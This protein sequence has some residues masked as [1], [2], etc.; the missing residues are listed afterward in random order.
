MKF[1]IFS[2]VTLL[3]VSFTSLAGIKDYDETYKCGTVRNP[4][5]RLARITSVDPCS[6]DEL[7]YTLS[8]GLKDE[9]KDLDV[10]GPSD[11]FTFEDGYSIFS[12][13]VDVGGNCYTF[14]TLADES[15]GSVSEIVLPEGV[16]LVESIDVTKILKA[17]R[18]FF[19][20]PIVFH[21]ANIGEVKSSSTFAGKIGKGF[22]WLG[23]TTF[24]IQ[25]GALIKDAC[26]G[27]KIDDKVY[28]VAKN[29]LN[30]AV[31]KL[32]TS[33]LQLAF[34]GVFAIDYSL[35]NF[36]KAAQ[37]QH[38]DNIRQIYFNYTYKQRTMPDWFRALDK[39]VQEASKGD[40][41]MSLTNIV[42]QEIQTVAQRFWKDNDSA[43]ETLK[44][45]KW[46]SK[47]EQK[48]LTEEMVQSLKYTMAQSGVFDRVY[49]SI[50]ERLRDEAVKKE[51]YVAKQ[52]NRKMV[53]AVKP[54]SA[55]G[56]DAQRNA[57]NKNKYAGYTVFLCPVNGS[58]TPWSFKLDD[59]GTGQIDFTVLG[60]F[61]CGCPRTCEIYA[62]GKVRGRDKPENSFK[63]PLADPRTT[64]FLPDDQP[65]EIDG[66]YELTSQTVVHKG[67]DTWVGK[68]PTSWRVKASGETMTVSLVGSGK[69][70]QVFTGKFDP[71]K[72]VFLF[73]QTYSS[74]GHN[75]E[76]RIELTF[77]G[78]G[79]DV[80][81]SGYYKVIRGACCEAGRARY[82]DQSLTEKYEGRKVKDGEK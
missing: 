52:L 21:K 27:E 47:E 33:G 72:G 9:L 49:S 77:T 5:T 17:N 67:G 60:F 59:A 20:E 7:R 37:E 78:S 22:T 57:D 56:G 63:F 50:M 76:R 80:K 65:A 14:L 4:G 71:K 68:T 3:V 39:R 74:L 18:N 44:I 11:A 16:K 61:Q 8:P 42:E 31:S 12:D 75:Y 32:G 15:F 73:S 34:A 36:A 62:P 55:R 70:S 19:R 81:F 28:G 46:P 53:I 13:L 64:I 10:E 45:E 79:D 6:I 23:Y 69:Q 35:G 1:R 26:N 82:F 41:T 38:T 29:I 24:A 48:N 54:S 40:I 51:E 58:G 25:V 30:I 2:L 66:L 43:I